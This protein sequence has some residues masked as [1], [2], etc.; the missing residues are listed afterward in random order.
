MPKSNFCKRGHDLCVVRKVSPCGTSKCG[1]CAREKAR[2]GG[3]YH[4]RKRLW[5]IA[6]REEYAAKRKTWPSRLTKRTATENRR[7][8]LRRKYALT[9]DEFD[10]MLAR[11]MGVCCICKEEN[12]GGRPL[13]V[14]H[15][16]A[17]GQVRGLLCH[18]CNVAVGSIRDSRAHFERIIDYIDVHSQLKLS[19]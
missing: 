6:N 13:F 16:H 18:R 9:V 12:T 10:N 14:D 11:Q 4:E 2:K 15:D 5:L 3:T 7:K 17:S 8:L 1:Q 19:L